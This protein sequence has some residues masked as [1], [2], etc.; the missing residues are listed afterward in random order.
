MDELVVWILGF[1]IVSMMGLNSY[2]TGRVGA[3][4][5]PIATAVR[6]GNGNSNHLDLV[7]KVAHLG[8]VLAAIHDCLVDLADMAEGVGPNIGF[9]DHAP[10]SRMP[11]PN[12][13]SLG[14]IVK[15]A[16]LNQ[17]MSGLANGSTQGTG[18][19]LRTE[20]QETQETDDHNSTE[21]TA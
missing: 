19:P 5:A 9:T 20:I 8:E 18:R 10:P 2:L 3:N 16:L 4:V 15:T 7:P 13:D 14:D 6:N 1:L 17:V 12:T 11:F 21:E